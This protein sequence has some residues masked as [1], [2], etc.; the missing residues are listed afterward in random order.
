MRAAF[1]LPLL[2]IL[3]APRSARADDFDFEYGV[4]WAGGLGAALDEVRP[5]FLG[6]FGMD[7]LVPIAGHHG[8]AAS[9]DLMVRERPSHPSDTVRPDGDAQLFYAWRRGERQPGGWDPW[10]AVGAGYRQRGTA[11]RAVVQHGVSV[12]LRVGADRAVGWSSRLGLFFD[13]TIGCYLA[14]S[15]SDPMNDGPAP[16]PRGPGCIDTA[17]STYSGG[18]RWSVRFR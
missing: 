2:V 8:I 13:W 14:K 16:G 18:L 11:D 12:A 5:V 3:V 4:R 15:Q 1:L 6:A 17:I 9:V 7:L 10:F